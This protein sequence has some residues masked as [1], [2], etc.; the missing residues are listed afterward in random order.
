LQTGKGHDCPVN[1][2]DQGDWTWHLDPVFSGDGQVEV[3]ASGSPDGD[4]RLF[5]GRRPLAFP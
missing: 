5:M 4:A 1:A 3:K 2:K